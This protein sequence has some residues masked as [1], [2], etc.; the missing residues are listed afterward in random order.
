MKKLIFSCLWSLLLILAGCQAHDDFGETKTSDNALSCDVSM[1]D[2]R[3]ELEKLLDDVYG[4]QTTRANEHGGKV[5]S[6]SYTHRE[7]VEAT[8]RSEEPDTLTYYIF[9]F[10]NNNGYAVMAGNSEMPSL[11]ALAETGNCIAGQVVVNP[12][13]HLYFK[14]MNDFYKNVGVD[15]SNF[16]GDETIK[17]AEEWQNTVI[18]PGNLCKVKWGQEDSYDDYCPI[19][20][21]ERAPTGCVAT[22]CAQLM[23]IY[24]YP[25]QYNGYSFNW[26]AMTASPYA[27]A[28]TTQ[29]QSQIARLMQQLGLPK[30]LDMQYGSQASGAYDKDIPR[31]L[32]NFGYAK[33][34]NVIDYNTTNVVTELQQGYPILVGGCRAETSANNK[35]EYKG[36]QWLCCGLLKRSREIKIYNRYRTYLGSKVEE[37]WYPFCN[38]GWDGN[39][40]GYYLSNAFDAYNKHY[41]EDLSLDTDLPNGVGRNYQYFLKTVIG[42]RK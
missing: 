7:L 10:A 19:I 39:A 34:G 5:I 41:D 17:I 2:A 13:T 23:S 6:T 22:A 32:K 4:K 30:N 25:A 35:T 18:Q 33:G 24:K 20:S 12:G 8:T 27:K 9:N 29:A 14:G 42:I 16:G 28:C 15:G 37:F 26:D 1:E 11:I 40:D 38:W 36:H 3:L 21:G 31:T